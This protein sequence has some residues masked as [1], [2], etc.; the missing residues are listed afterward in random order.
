MGVAKLWALRVFEPVQRASAEDFR[1]VV[2]HTRT[3]S[4]KDP[5]QNKERV[6]SQ[7]PTPKKTG[8]NKWNLNLQGTLLQNKTSCLGPLMD[9]ETQRSE[10]TVKNHGW[11]AP[12]RQPICETN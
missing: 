6:Y 3:L 9:Q 1:A 8:R 4:G 10:I 5:P 11:A 7:G 2:G 12:C